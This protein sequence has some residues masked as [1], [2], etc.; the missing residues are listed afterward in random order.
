MCEHGSGR[1]LSRVYIYLS[2]TQRACAILSSATSLV[3]SD[4][5]TLSH[6]RHDFRG[7]KVLKIM[8][9]NS[10]LILKGIQRD[11]VINVKTSSCKVSVILNGF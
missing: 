8:C 1:V 2:R 9:F 10:T 7:K 4:F 3:P 6:K 11:I 5:P